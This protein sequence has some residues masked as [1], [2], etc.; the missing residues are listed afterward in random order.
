MA[1]I[2]NKVHVQAS[3]LC[4]LENEVKKPYVNNLQF[5]K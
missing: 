3:R 5:I 2:G 4:E 1:F